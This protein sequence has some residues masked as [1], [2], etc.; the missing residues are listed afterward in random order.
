LSKC[1]LQLD[2]DEGM[3]CLEAIGRLTR[4][5]YLDLSDNEL[6]PQGL[7]QLTGLSRLQEMEKTWEGELTPGDPIIT[8]QHWDAFWAAVWG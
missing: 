7:M 5:T 3:T 8:Q 6:P 4:L 1:E 2:S